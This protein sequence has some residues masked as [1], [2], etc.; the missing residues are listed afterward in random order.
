MSQFEASM[1]VVEKLAKSEDVK[2]DESKHQ[3]Y[4]QKALSSWRQDICGRRGQPPTS[5]GS[6]C[7]GPKMRNQDEGRR[8]QPPTRFGS[9]CPGLKRRNQDTGR[10]GQTPKIC[11]SNPRYSKGIWEVIME[12]IMVL[13][14][15]S[16]I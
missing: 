12:Y 16:S 2:L 4:P 3:K 11:G 7:P 1:T 14:S 8:G 5:S 15:R 6:H 13:K 10:R 9:H